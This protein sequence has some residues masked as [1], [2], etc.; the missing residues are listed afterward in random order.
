MDKH[1]ESYKLLLLGREVTLIGEPEPEVYTVT[2]YNKNLTKVKLSWF[3][4]PITHKGISDK[5]GYYPL[6][7]VKPYNSKAMQLRPAC[8]EGQT[9]ITTDGIS[10]TIKYVNKKI[11]LLDKDNNIIKPKKGKYF[12]EEE[13]FLHTHNFYIDSLVADY[14][15]DTPDIGMLKESLGLFKN[16]PTMN[17]ATLLFKEAF[18][19]ISDVVFLITPPRVFTLRD[20]VRIVLSNISSSIKNKWERGIFM[21]NLDLFWSPCD[22]IKK[23]N[24]RIISLNRDYPD[25]EGYP[26]IL[27]DEYTDRDLIN[28]DQDAFLVA[29]WKTIMNEMVLSFMSFDDWQE[30]NGYGDEV[31]FAFESKQYKE[32]RKQ[33]DEEVAR[34]KNTY[35]KYINSL[36]D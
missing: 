22:Y 23:M 20:R 8:R 2:H 11:T 32:L 6:Y 31:G 15:I 17:N 5:N 12:K 26:G 7:L 29:K 3:E 16:C 34:Y 35:I 36:W 27:E 28:T 9:V 24:I 30:I 4:Q 1:I 19:Y 13:L 18:E 14:K 10:G 33:Y 21:S 25:R